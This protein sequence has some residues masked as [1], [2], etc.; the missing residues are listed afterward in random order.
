M[1][2]NTDHHETSKLTATRRK[3]PVRTTLIALFAALIAAGTF[4]AIPMP[5][6]VPIVLQNM[7]ALLAGMVLGP[8]AGGASVA[9]YLVAGAIGAPIFSG[10]RGGF[11]HFLS[12]SGG[13]LWGYLLCAIT[14]GL[15]LGRPRLTVKL[16]LWRII[17]AAVAG[18]LIVYLPGLIQLKVILNTNWAG[19][20]VAGFVPYVIGDAIKG[21]VAVLAAGRLRRA[22]AS[23][24]NDA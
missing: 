15:I 14:S 7:F 2:L 10:A 23:V 5:S 22:V 16:P 9:L 19:A 4:I 12:P 20:F 13:Y 6:G 21:A 24:L 3:A 11:V 8:V 17:A 1:S 18:L